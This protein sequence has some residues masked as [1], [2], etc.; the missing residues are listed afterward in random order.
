MSTQELRYRPATT[1]EVVT[2]CERDGMRVRFEHFTV[3][4]YDGRTW[5]EVRHKRFATGRVKLIDG[6]P[7]VKHH[8]KLEPITATAVDVVEAETGELITRCIIGLKLKALADSRNK[9]V[10][11]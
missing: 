10:T 5:N 6:V 8:R 2:R 3:E 4:T 1:E 7:H 11:N 9:A